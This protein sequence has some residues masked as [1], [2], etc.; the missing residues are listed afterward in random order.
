MK[1]WQQV[2]HIKRALGQVSRWT[3]RKRLREA[4][5]RTVSKT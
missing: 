5:H 3:L 1:I 2:R 4:M